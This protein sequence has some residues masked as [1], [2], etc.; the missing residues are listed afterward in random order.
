MEKKNKKQLDQLTTQTITQTFLLK[1]HC[2]LVCR[3]KCF[4]YISHFNHQNI[5]KIYT[6]ELRLNKINFY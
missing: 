3:Q 6:Q 2:T 1:N 5:K 4:M